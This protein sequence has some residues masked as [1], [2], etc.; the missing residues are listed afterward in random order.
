LVQQGVGKLVLTGINTNFSGGIWATNFLQMG[1]GVSGTLG[2]GPVTNNRAL[3]L[4]V[5]PNPSSTVAVPSSI[6]G[7][8]SVTNIGPGLTLLSGTNTYTGN[9]VIPEGTIQLGSSGA[10]PSAT[11]LYMDANTSPGLTGTLDLNGQN[12]TIASLQGGAGGNGTAGFVTSLIVNNASG[13]GTNTLTINGSITNT[14]FYGQILDNN[15]AGTG[16]VALMLNNYAALTL[17]AGYNN[18]GT[19]TFPSLF[20]GG[21]T[22]SNAYLYLGV[23]NNTDLSSGTSAAG[24]GN[25][26]LEGGQGT[27]ITN[28]I[29]NSITGY[30]TNGTLFATGAVGN[31]G[32]GAQAC[33]V[34][35]ITV[36]AGQFGTIVG[37][38]RGTFTSTL[39]GGGTLF[40]NTQYARDS[41][42]LHDGGFNGT[43]VFEAITPFA[44][45]GVAA[46]GTG[47]A[48]PLNATEGFANA[49]V[50]LQTNNTSGAP[51]S[52][53]AVLDICGT[54]A[55]NVLPWGSLAG[56]DSTV[57][58]DGGTNPGSEGSAATIYAVGSLN[59][60]TTVGAVIRD[61]GA[62]LRK[63]GTGTL[64]L[65]N[66]T[67]SFGGQ[68]VVSNGT[69]S[70]V[71][72][73]PPGTTIISIVTNI[74]STT[75][76]VV[77]N[78]NTLVI[79]YPKS[80]TYLIGTNITI[81]SPG[82]LD[83][84]QVG[85]N[86]LYLGHNGAQSLFGNGTLNGSL[87]AT[88]T[89]NAMVVSPG[90]RA[91][92]AGVNPGIF[93][94]NMTVN[95]SALFGISS[96]FIMNINRTS[97]P[98][99]DSFTALGGLNI[100]AAALVVN[101]AGDTAF[102][103]QTTNVFKFFPAAVQVSLGATGGG[104]TNISVPTNLPAGMFWVTNLNGTLAGYPTVPAGSMAIV[105][106]NPFVPT[107]PAGGAFKMTT[108]VSGGN[109]TLAWPTNQIG[110]RLQAQTNTL[111]QGLG[112]NW[113]DIDAQF[114]PAANTTN[115]VVIPI[116]TG[117][118]SVFYRLIYP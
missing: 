9:T 3:I 23:N 35:S 99:Y 109:L 27:I 90:R 72:L 57:A 32:N 108:S 74:T 100:N 97:T 40:F 6:S 11:A 16:K 96:T 22:V 80:S 56:G 50:F 45:V 111:A 54:V 46:G 116:Y 82:V 26:T 18:L 92:A 118:G 88:N 59:T 73:S 61:A 62:G 68:L 98:S 60:S 31:N 117:N 19:A 13:A 7:S 38:Q 5:G 49:S 79:N 34:A 67:L 51:A 85:S 53:P 93:P 52:A 86:T 37:A 20:S 15:N 101:N 12:V 110:Y 91:S 81:V 75:T 70:F 24:I 77:T 83:L 65:T 66:N 102:P 8:G 87:T 94:G 64:T 21:I 44:S 1:N 105:N 47:G 95:G 63:V 89:G 36:P 10:L 48:L 43:I 114:T 78:Y 103:G 107:G 104:I 84:S 113:V 29:T 41:L 76:N 14:T 112:T 55:N 30:P 106:T 115:Q 17:G 25:I 4:D 2:T 58:L 42:T 28:Q 69:L 39:I 71:P 33:T